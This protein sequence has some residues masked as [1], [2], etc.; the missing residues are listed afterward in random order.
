MAVRA[1]L[2]DLAVMRDLSVRLAEREQD[3]GA[4]EGEGLA[5]CAHGVDGRNPV[6][7]AWR[8]RRRAPLRPPL[9]HAQEA[10]KRRTSSLWMASKTRVTTVASRLRRVNHVCQSE[11]SERRR[12][13]ASESRQTRRQRQINQV[14][15]PW[16]AAH[17][18]L[19]RL[20]GAVEDDGQRE[21]CRLEALD[22]LAHVVANLIERA[23]AEPVRPRA[24]EEAD[25]A[26]AIDAQL[27]AVSDGR[28]GQRG[29]SRLPV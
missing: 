14:R 2:I 29:T 22:K 7:A 25:E 3:L 21:A 5:E 19:D 9:S 4:G 23:S 16:R 26:A 20:N 24:Q 1:Y 13:T 27:A 28:G 11:L 18:S 6:R 12:L 8:L 17:R 15:V 10:K